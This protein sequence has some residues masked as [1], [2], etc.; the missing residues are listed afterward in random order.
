MFIFHWCDTVIDLQGTVGGLGF[1]ETEDRL[2][3]PKRS[4]FEVQ[5]YIN[6]LRGLPN[7]LVARDTFANSTARPVG[8][9]INGTQSEV[10]GR[11]WGAISTVVMG[12][13]E[14]TTSIGGSQEH[15]AGIP[16]NP[17][18]DP[19][20]PV[21]SVE[22]D[23]IVPGS[24]WIGLGFSLSSTGGYWGHGQLWAHLGPS[25][26]YTIYA[27]ALNHNLRTGTIPGFKPQGLNHLLVRHNRAENTASVVIN[28]ST[29]LFERDL[30][31]PPVS[32]V[33]SLAFAGFHIQTAAGSG[34][35]EARVDNLR[36]HSGPET[37]IFFDGF[38]TANLSGWSSA[39]PPDC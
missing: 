14:V 25:G 11:V 4:F 22:A 30:D 9:P 21:N 13:S 38:E 19:A 7:Y 3:R 15:E 6:G 2:F 26:T 17:P 28:G 10:G 34:A 16:F 33:P 12:T 32:F 27:D 18:V 31:D 37:W 5:S 1:V 20:K 23:L 24:D 8:G 39:C 29:V 35:G 36:V